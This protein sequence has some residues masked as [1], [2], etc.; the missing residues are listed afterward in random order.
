M[1][2][3]PTQ[4]ADRVREVGGRIETGVTVESVSGLPETRA[5]SAGADR[6]R[7]SA[8]ADQTRASRS[9]PTPEPSMPTRSS[10]RP[11]RRPLAN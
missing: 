3:I 1:E 10:S 6:T 8:S 9:R 11:I 2:A 5:V 4:L 7:A